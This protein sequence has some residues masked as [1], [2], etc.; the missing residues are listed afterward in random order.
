MNRTLQG[1]I[2]ASAAFSL[3]IAFALTAEISGAAFQKRSASAARRAKK[4]DE[5]F[6]QNCARCHGADGSGDTP[7]GQRYHAPDFT[8][9]DW[10]K[11][12]N[13]PGKRKLAKI[14]SRGK[15]DMP[16]FGKKLKKSDIN[17]LVDQVR[18]FRPAK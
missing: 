14:V 3:F 12:M 17:L 2:G 18:S 4:A 5:L 13:N 6:K 1:A 15:E 10:W 11:K 16:A 9:P 7:L 8:D